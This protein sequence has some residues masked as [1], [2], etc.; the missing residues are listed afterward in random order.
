MWDSKNKFAIKFKIIGMLTILE[1]RGSY[2][3]T[4]IHSSF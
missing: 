4:I 3:K 2:E 1:K